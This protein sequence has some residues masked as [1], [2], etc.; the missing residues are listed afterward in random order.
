MKIK[1]KYLSDIEKVNQI[2][3]G[4]WI[5]LRSAEDVVLE[6]GKH[7]LIPLG[8]AMKLPENHEAHISPRSSTFKNWG[9][10]MT[11]SVGVVDFSYS[12]N[13]DQWYFSAFA[14][15][16]SE[17]HKNDRICQFRIVEIQPP[18]EFEECETLDE[19]DRGGFG[20]TGIS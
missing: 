11:N 18:I 1:I 20:S 4:N 5:D 14:T 10:L 19:K 6:A 17:I 13:N 15:R 12:G 7:Y 3:K 8:V 2:S 9:I 16:N